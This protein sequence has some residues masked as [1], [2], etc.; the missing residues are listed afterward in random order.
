MRYRSAWLVLVALL[1]LGCE[2][3]VV[4]VLGT[5]VQYSLYGVLNPLADSQSVR[6]YPI[7]ET[8]VPEEDPELVAEVRSVDLNTGEE[9]VWRQTVV[10]DRDGG[11]GYIY[12]APFRAEYGHQYR[13]TVAGP[14]GGEA[15]AT[16]EV[17]GESTIAMGTPILSRDV[18]APIVLSGP[19][20]NLIR[21]EL[22]YFVQYSI[23]F[24][25]GN[26]PNIV[27]DT[28]V[29]PFEGRFTQRSNE[30][31]VP[32]DLSAA[33]D[34]IR[35]EILNGVSFDQTY[36]ISLLALRFD[37]VVANAAWQPPGGDFN[38]LVLIQPGTMSNVEG[39]FGF[40]GAGYRVS[41]TWAP[42]ADVA[43]EAGF[44]P[45]GR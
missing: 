14:D 24:I 16:V 23:G 32:V 31:I 13:I 15:E 4:A 8:L 22:T 5:D 9:R 44:R 37:A 7:R 17:P 45:F 43:D 2:E 30:L 40:I 19:V 3:D 12:R 34:A 26:V 6:V 27:G 39:G 36:G 28:L 1:A 21:I 42:P 29:V 25:T 35:A 20:T 41:L 38:P 11:F 10:V 33:F 18:V